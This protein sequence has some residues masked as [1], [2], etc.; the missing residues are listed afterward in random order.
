MYGPTETT[1]WST[2]APRRPAPRAPIPI[3]RPIANTQVHVLDEDRQPVPVGVV[4]E[5]YIGGDGVALGYLRPARAHRRALRRRS[6]RAR[7]RRAD[8]PHRRPRPLAPARRHG[9]LECL[10]RIDFQVKVRGYRIELGEIE[11]ALAR[12][13]AIAQ[14]VVVAREDRP[15]DVRLVAYV[16]PRAGGRRRRDDARCAS[17]SRRPL[18]DYMIP[19][20]FVT[21]AALP[22]TGNGKVDRKALPGAVGP[23]ARR[24]GR[25]GRAAHADRAARRRRVSARRSRCRGS[26]CTT[27]SS[28]SAATR[29]WSRR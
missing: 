23:G 24:P 6:V 9:A 19:A 21:L 4:G 8:V 29:C 1:V 14:A 20:R 13:P 26:A 12:H 15:G 22:L 10:G 3:G 7:A 16:V 18:P 17:T 27:T 2:L 25:G 11:A 5:L 28:R